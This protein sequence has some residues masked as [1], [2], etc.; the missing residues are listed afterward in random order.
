MVGVSQRRTTGPNRYR[1]SV[2]TDLL[3]ASPD[4]GR[5]K[6]HSQDGV[7][8]LGRS[9]FDQPVLGLFTRLD[10]VLRHAAKLTAKDRFEACADLASN[11]PGA[12]SEAEHLAVNL[13]DDVARKIVHR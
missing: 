7:S 12:D 1:S 13:L 6:S 9:G 4:L 8:S 10:E 2:S 3:P 11:V 5:I